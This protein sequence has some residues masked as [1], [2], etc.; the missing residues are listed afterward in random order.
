[1]HCSVFAIRDVACGNHYS[2]YKQ[3]YY[4]FVR[5]VVSKITKSNLVTTPTLSHVTHVTSPS[6]QLVLN[7]P[8]ATIVVTFGTKIINKD[9][10]MK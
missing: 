3:K 5:F 7:T 4:T 8:A 1:M 9:D 6:N 2:K 10:L